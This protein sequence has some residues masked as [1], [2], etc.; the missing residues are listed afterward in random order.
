[1]QR[2]CGTWINEEIKERRHRESFGEVNKCLRGQ[3]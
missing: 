3:D 1:M 2:T